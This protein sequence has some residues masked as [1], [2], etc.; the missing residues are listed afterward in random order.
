[1]FNNYPAT[2]LFI[3]SLLFLMSLTFFTPLVEEWHILIAIL[4]ESLIFVLKIICIFFL[5][6][7]IIELI[8]NIHFRKRHH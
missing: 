1:M 2:Y 4:L 6:S 5:F 7:T 8:N 3:L